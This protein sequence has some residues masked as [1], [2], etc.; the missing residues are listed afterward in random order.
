[1]RVSSFAVARPSPVDRNPTTYIFFY[2]V[3]ASSPSAQ[4][5]QLTYTV[6][7]GRR[8]SI[9]SAFA[10]L[11]RFTAATVNGRPNVIITVNV[12]SGN[13]NVAYVGLRA[14]TVGDKDTIN[15]TNAG[16]YVAGT[17]IRAFDQD[18]ST[19]GTVDRQMGFTILEFDA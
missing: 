12:G 4:T 6:P 11:A 14:N 8:A 3:T 13:Q 2:G 5:Q 1:M 7:A 17:I 15:I 19:L 10:Y 9:Q 18:D 16:Q